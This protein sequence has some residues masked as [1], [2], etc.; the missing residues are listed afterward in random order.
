MSNVNLNISKTEKIGNRWTEV[1]ASDES[2]KFWY[3][4]NGGTGNNGNNKFT[5]KSAVQTFELSFTGNDDETYK[6]TA[7]LNKSDPTDLSGLVNSDSLVTITDVCENAGD[8]SW[9]VTVAVKATPELTF[10]CDPM[11]KNE[12]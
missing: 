10:N 8:Y 3:K 6:F 12:F 7:Y 5:T 4:Y 11:V 1:T 2:T 9:G